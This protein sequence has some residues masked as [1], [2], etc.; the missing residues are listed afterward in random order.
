D[1]WPLSEEKADTLRALVDEQ[2]NQGHLVPTTS[3]W[4]T[5]VFV[6]KKKS[7]KW[8]LLHD[9]QQVNVVI[10]D[11]GMLQPGTPSPTVI[12]RQWDIMI[13][14]LKD[15][16]FTIPLAPEDAPRF[17]FS[18]PVV[19]HQGPRLRYH[20]MVLP[21]GMKNSPTICQMY[22]A[23]ALSPI[24]NKYPDLICESNA[25]PA[26]TRTICYHYMDDI[27]IAG[28]DPKELATVMTDMLEGLK[29][30]SLQIAPEK[31]QVQAPW[32]YLGW[33]ILEHTI[34]PQPITLQSNIKTLNDLQKLVGT[35]NW[36]RPLLGID[37]D[38]L[39]PLFELLKG[40]PEL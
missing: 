30:Y 2:M 25:I 34:Q 8:R 21:Q 19:N 38:M 39:T 7:G 9:L 37:N 18:L 35:I 24:R 27:L 3:P 33:T 28:R 13:I 29:K 40:A 4:N 23:R 14:D 31:V 17:A 26:E 22:V 12:P 15:C 1:Q 20:W 32:K 5:P 16:F 36:V 6:I 11:M 10:Q